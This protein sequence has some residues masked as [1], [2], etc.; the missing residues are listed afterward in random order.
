MCGIAGR[1]NRDAPVDPIQLDG[2]A[3]LIAHRGPDG[4]GR[5]IDGT[6]GLVHRRLAIV[7]LEGGRQPVLGERG[8]MALVYNGE[9]YNHME[10]RAELEPLGHIFNDRCDTEAVLHAHEEWGIAAAARL[11]GMFAYAA[12]DRHARRLTLVRDPLGIKPL[13]YAHLPSGDL[14][15][16]SELK[17]LLVEPA[18]ARSL[19]EEALA[20]YLALR[21]VPAPATLL[22]GVRKLEPGCALTWHEGR[23]THTRW[24]S[25]P[26]LG[27]RPAPATWVEAGGRLCALLDEVVGLWRMG[28]VPL[29]AF[30]SGGLDSTLVTALL[31]E[32]ARRA[33]D[34]AP[35]TFSIGYAGIAAGADDELGWARQAAQALGTRHTEMTITG[36]QVADSLPRI[37][38]H[39]DEPVGDPAAIPLWFLARRAR[40]EVTIALSGEGADEAFG[41]YA[42]YGRLLRAAQMRRVPGIAALAGALLPHLSGRLA[43][44]ARL[45]ATP[46]EES[47]HGVARAFDVPP[48]STSPGAVHRALAP[49]WARARRAPTL[50]G[51]LLAFDQEAWLADDLLVKAD[52][53]TMAH[54]LELRPPLLDSRLI[55][56]LAGWPDAWKHDGRVGKRILRRAAQGI[57]PRAILERPKIGFGT[58]AG[59]WLRGPLRLLAHD[60]LTGDRSLAGERGGLVRVRGLLDEQ[61]R[62][63][64]RTNE[65]WTLL[66]L[67]LWRREVVCSVTPTRT[68]LAAGPALELAG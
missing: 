66:A 6:A 23:L 38:W 61:N 60:L 31:V 63:R 7:D 53:M 33:G 37:A 22:A 29:G 24:W 46:A 3:A 52:K 26:V 68:R 11:R 14:L 8:R 42:A 62:G 10:L 1:V 30:L 17:A 47:Y 5:F 20:A 48:W 54:G 36:A 58:P 18:V 34:S 49:S 45:L 50:L 40:T 16:A 21:Y 13:Y 25:P 2:M 55:E 19:D 4:Q 35:R 27:T 44:A 41:G 65:L 57:V 39:L 15:F 12:W 9:I 67:E 28:D 32:Q 51:R 43:R 64:D 56:E 59:A